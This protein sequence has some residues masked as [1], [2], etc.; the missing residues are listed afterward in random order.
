MKFNFTPGHWLLGWV[1]FMLMLGT[2]IAHGW[3][4]L[5]GGAAVFGILWWYAPDLLSIWH[6]D[7]PEDIR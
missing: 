1:L 7:P 5:V 2:G 6:G 4:L 3:W